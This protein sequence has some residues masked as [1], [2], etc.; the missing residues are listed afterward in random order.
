MQYKEYTIEHK[1]HIPEELLCDSEGMEWF[2]PWDGW[3]KNFGGKFNLSHLKGSNVDWTGYKIRVPIKEKNMLTRDMLK[4]GDIIIY[5]TKLGTYSVMVLLDSELQD[6]CCSKDEYF[7]LSL[8]LRGQDMC[9][10][11]SLDRVAQKVVRPR[12][13]TEYRAFM[14]GKTPFGNIIWKKPITHIITIDGTDVQLS[15]ESFQS[16]KKQFKE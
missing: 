13:L 14:Q 16:L 8:S 9:I 2:S 4:T 12:S 5:K 7:T 10:S 11:K 15:E 1:Y 3:N 6:I